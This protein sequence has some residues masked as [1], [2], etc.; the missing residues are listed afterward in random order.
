[1]AD[2]RQW[3]LVFENLFA[4]H[5][6]QYGILAG[7]TFA[8]CSCAIARWWPSRKIQANSITTR[9]QI[10]SRDRLFV[11]NDRSL[12]YRWC[13]NVVGLVSLAHSVALSEF[14]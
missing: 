11:T 1:M 8:V 9:R 6:I 14:E 13:T 7:I 4:F 5:F 12:R 2:L 3:L 10:A